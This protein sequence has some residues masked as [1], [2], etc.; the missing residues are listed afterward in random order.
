[1]LPAPRTILPP[2]DRRDLILR[3]AS[4]VFAAKGYAGSKI[5][6]IAHAAEMS[7]GLLY[8][9]Y[10]SKE[11]LFTELLRISF[12]KLNA[13]AEGLLQM[14]LP[15]EKKIRLALDTL[16]KDIA[17]DPAFSERVLLIAQA[18][19]SDGIPAPSK[20]IIRAERHP[21]YVAISRIMA[22]GQ[23][24]GTILPGSPDDLSMLFW[25]TIKGIALHK[26]SFGAEFQPPETQI[27]YRLFLC[28]KGK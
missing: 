9:Y 15:P 5:A 10:E 16:L 20:A 3:C 25:T 24:L 19:V 26:V 28:E 4:R 12:E 13:A 11:I 6:D 18:S 23:A 22:A 7:Q 1:M 2:D 14:A 27:L 21:P 8:R 17:C